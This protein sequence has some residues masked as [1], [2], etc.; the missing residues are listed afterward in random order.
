MAARRTVDHALADLTKA[1]NMNFECTLQPCDGR[2]E[3]RV[4]VYDDE[5][6]QLMEQ[7]FI[8]LAQGP[9]YAL[10]SALEDA[11]KPVKGS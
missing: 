8:V 3:A 1:T 10:A 2:F 7:D 11:L 9:A 4:T 6:M 5:E